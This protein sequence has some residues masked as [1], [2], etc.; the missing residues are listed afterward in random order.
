MSA[1]A[2]RDH[3]G[4]PALRALQGTGLRDLAVTAGQGEGNGSADS[5]LLL[6]QEPA[7]KE[8]PGC[9]IV[10]VEVA[11]GAEVLARKEL[12]VGLGNQ[13]YEL[14]V[15]ELFKLLRRDRSPDSKF[16]RFHCSCAAEACLR[17][18]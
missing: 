2:W 4:Y 6:V 12:T 15:R 16:D 8:A 14:L 9:S 7:A 18:G 5:V 13:L 11:I 3:A 10:K 17:I 1:T